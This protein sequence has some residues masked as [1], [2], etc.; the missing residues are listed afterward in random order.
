MEDLS[1]RSS[2]GTSTQDRFPHAKKVAVLV[3]LLGLIGGI[4]AITYA[5]TSATATFGSSVESAPSIGDNIWAHTNA[6]DSSVEIQENYGP[7]DGIP[8]F[9][10]NIIG[11]TGGS[12]ES[13]NLFWIEPHPEYNTGIWMQVELTNRSHITERYTSFSENLAVWQL[14]DGATDPA[15]ETNWTKLDDINTFIT[16]IGPTATFHINQE[17][18]SIADNRPLVVTIESG[19][20]WAKEELADYGQVT[21]YLEID[22]GGYTDN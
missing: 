4:F 15:E 16:A 8:Y 3:V 5:T 21:H 14:N 22:E 17:N 13:G 9:P 11:G 2:S 10:E 7:H 1:N 19:E 6:D 18:A 20:F 12:I